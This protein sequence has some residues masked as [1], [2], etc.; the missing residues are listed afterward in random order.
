M[1]KEEIQAK[2]H[3]IGEALADVSVEILKANCCLMARV[4]IE[5]LNVAGHASIT[6][7]V[8][9]SDPVPGLAE[10]LAKGDVMGIV[11]AVSGMPNPNTGTEL[12]ADEAVA[13][14]EEL[15]KN[16]RA[17]PAEKP[18]EGSESGDQK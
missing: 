16:L 9:A 7:K 8:E 4:N 5:V 14:A 17:K 2:L 1:T 13:Q 11:V 15:M 18:A 3:E 10:A 12:K 6:L